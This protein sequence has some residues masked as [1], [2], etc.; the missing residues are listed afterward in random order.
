MRVREQHPASRE[1]IDVGRSNSRVTAEAADPIIHVINRKEQDIRSLPI[2]SS[3]RRSDSAKSGCQSL[4]SRDHRPI[5][6]ASDPLRV[7]SRTRTE[8]A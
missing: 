1:R 4:P 8:M 2:L 3:F 7:G 5:I 6:I